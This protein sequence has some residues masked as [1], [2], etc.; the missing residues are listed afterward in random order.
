MM[1]VV[2]VTEPLV[3]A[4]N[5]DVDLRQLPGSPSKKRSSVERGDQ[6]P[7]KKTKAEVFDE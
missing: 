3:D 7:T 5:K 4:A 1:I 6:P 2:M